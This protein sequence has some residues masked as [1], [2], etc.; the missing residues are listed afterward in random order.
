MLVVAAAAPSLARHAETKSSIRGRVTDTS[1]YAM[2]GAIVVARPATGGPLLRVATPGNGHYEMSADVGPVDVVAAVDGFDAVRVVD[3]RVRDT[4]FE[5]DFRLSLGLKLECIVVEEPPYGTIR[6]T[7]AD[8]KGFPLPFAVVHVRQSTGYRLDAYG[9]AD[10]EGRYSANAPAGRN[11]V[12]AAYPGY[13]AQPRDVVVSVGKT[14]ALDLTAL[15]FGS[16]TPSTETLRSITNC[17][18]LGFEH[19]APRPEARL[20]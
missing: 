6:G 1:G 7:V 19:P 5:L 2:P 11:Q 12:S 20:R 10:A 15:M 3:A 13:V 16:R 17:G 14:S 18:R 9:Y 4:P 8:D